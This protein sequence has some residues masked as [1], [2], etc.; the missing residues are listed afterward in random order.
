MGQRQKNSSTTAKKEDKRPSKNLNV[1]PERIAQKLLSPDLNLVGK[2]KGAFNI[3]L[4]TDKKQYVHIKATG[5]GETAHMFEIIGGNAENRR[6]TIDLLKKAIQRIEVL[7]NE[8]LEKTLKSPEKNTQKFE[9]TNAKSVVDKAKHLVTTA[10]NTL[11]DTKTIKNKP[12]GRDDKDLGN[13]AV[14]GLRAALSEA[15]NNLR[16]ASKTTTAPDLKALLDTI[17]PDQKTLNKL[18]VGYRD[19]VTKSLADLTTFCMTLDE[20][21]KNYDAEQGDAH[22]A[23]KR[24]FFAAEQDVVEGRVRKRLAEGKASLDETDA[25]ALSNRAFKNMY[26]AR[27]KPN[28]ISVLLEDLAPTNDSRPAPTAPAVLHLVQRRQSE[29]ASNAVG[30]II[31]KTDS[32]LEQVEAMRN[33]PVVVTVGSAGTGK[34]LFSI[35]HALQEYKQSKRRICIFRPMKELGGKETM[36]YLP[37]DE[38]AKIAPYFRP[39]ARNLLVSLGGPEKDSSRKEA[40]RLLGYDKKPSDKAE[41]SHPLVEA[42]FPRAAV[43][44]L[45]LA[46]LR[47]DTIDNATIIIEEAQNLTVDEVKAVLTRAGNNTQIILN[48][49]TT[50]TDL[51]LKDRNGRWLD[52]KNMPGLPVLLEL[53][54]KPKATDW[55][56]VVEH[57][58]KNVVRSPVAAAAV[59]LFED[60]DA[61]SD[62]I[63]GACYE[64]YQANVAKIHTHPAAAAG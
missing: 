51:P 42:L 49:D 7:E 13:A 9:L 16:V 48:G 10:N 22:T 35:A 38:T 2:I 54:K 23:A 57:G 36:G 37:G 27:L 61:D 30:I 28:D 12:P 18:P 40:L 59:A 41:A 64:N 33:K 6:K 34:S 8:A 25:R 56:A 46:Y 63:M 17:I 5:R 1:G 11:K 21:I 62:E 44:L 15:S 3:D 60:F 43:Q 29:Y 52:E 19:F 50:Q 20:Q 45:P 31:P 4:K 55:L 47:G 39:I 32:Q 24:S 58:A 53:A 26:D 14:N